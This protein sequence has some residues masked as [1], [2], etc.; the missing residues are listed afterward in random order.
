MVQIKTY[1]NNYQQGVLDLIL[2]IQRNEFTIDITAEDQPDL[3]DIEKFYQ[4]YN[5]NFWVAVN[6]GEVIGTVALLDIGGKALALRKMFV[7]AAYRGKQYAIAQSLLQVAVNWATE[8]GMSNIF[9]GTTAQF[10]AAHRFYEKNNFRGISPEELP[11]SFPR[12]KV[13][14]RFYQLTLVSGSSTS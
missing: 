5:G 14:S 1:T 8:L 7:A 13:D 4:R 11:D 12:M 2:N 3:Q 9:L 6:D 10:L